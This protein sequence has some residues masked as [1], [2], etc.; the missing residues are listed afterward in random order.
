MKS[1]QFLIKV[2]CSS[3]IIFVMS[4]CS[5]HKPN[6]GSFQYFSESATEC[7]NKIHRA[8]VKLPGK[9]TLSSIFH[10]E[11][12]GMPEN[13]QINFRSVPY[14]TSEALDNGVKGSAW[15]NCMMDKHAV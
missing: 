13:Q 5:D 10:N 1:I 2:V 6:V 8:S 4:A 15:K 11:V 3:S 14:V 7:S 9:T 12:F